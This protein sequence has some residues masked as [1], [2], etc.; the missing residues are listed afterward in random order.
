MNLPALTRRLLLRQ[1]ACSLGS[2]AL[3]SLLS[4]R[5]FAGE[6]AAAQGPMTPRAPHF[7]PKATRVIFLSMAGAP[8]QIDLFDDKPKL[9]ELN[10]QDIPESYTK[11]ERFAFIKGTPKMLGSPFSVRMIA[12]S[13]AMLP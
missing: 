6:P 2:V 1:T 7:A 9:R 12:T 4:P 11:G 3:A 13:S 5:L 8:S 10:G